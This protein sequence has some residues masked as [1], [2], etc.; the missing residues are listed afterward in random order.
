MFAVVTF[1]R[2]GHVADPC[3]FT[4][5]EQLKAGPDAVAQQQRR[6]LGDP[7]PHRHP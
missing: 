6:P 4:D 7:A 5:E 2:S 1:R 3:D